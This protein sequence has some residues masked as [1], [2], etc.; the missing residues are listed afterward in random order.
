MKILTQLSKAGILISCMFILTSGPTYSQA[1]QKVETKYM[2]P[3]AL[4]LFFAPTDD[5]QQIVIQKFKS[6]PMVSKFDDHSVDFFDLKPNLPPMPRKPSSEASLTALNQYY[7]KV[8]EIDSLKK[9]AITQYIGSVSKPIVGL[10]WSR[11]ANGDFSTEL[12]SQRGSFTATDADVLADN[13]AATTR[14]EMLGEQ[15][16]NKTYCLLYEINQIRTMQEVYDEMDAAGAK[17]KG[18]KPVE[19]T[20]EGYQMEY[21]VNL[22]KLNFG[23]SVSALFYQNLWTSIENHDANKVRAWDNASFPMEFIKNYSG[24]VSSV[25]PID[26]KSSYYIIKKRKTMNE[27]LEDLPYATQENAITYFTKKVEDF[28]I[29]VTIYEEYPLTAKIGTK[30][31]LKLDQRFFIYEIQ[32][33]EKTNQQVKKRKGVARAT[34]KIS[35]NNQMATGETLPSKF[36]QQGGK[37]IYQGMLM[38]EHNDIGM[39][40]S[41]GYRTN[42]ADAAMS[43]VYLGLDYNVSKMLGKFLSGNSTPG[44]IYLGASITVNT[45]NDVTPGHISAYGPE[46]WATDEG[47]WSGNTLALDLTLSKEMYITQKGNI[48]LLPSATYGV[49]TINFSKMGEQSL[50]TDLN[51]DESQMKQYYW[52]ARTIQFGFGIGA[53]LGPRLALILEPKYV[54]KA[55][56]TDGNS[57]ALTQYSSDDSLEGT[58]KDTFMKIG[59]S[60]NSLPILLSLKVRL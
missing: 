32:L 1:N 24:S 23:D 30:E 26:P 56:Y 27:L 43:G 51:L 9:I 33:N 13:A 49:S 4:N 47:E 3:S 12:V 52:G 44:G 38:I 40:L 7:K 14:L 39:Q 42:G 15:L 36:K 50:T 60:N 45:M 19:R 8:Q 21:T 16:L 35:N 5:E 34:S 2:R 58:W 25:Q 6:L 18:Y 41:A 31:G 53:N 46:S 20:Q 28:Q 55:S 17:V 57:S 54:M 10:W 59:E 48:F 11:D 37:K 22:Y 29:K